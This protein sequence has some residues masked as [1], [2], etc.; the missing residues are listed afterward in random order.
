MLIKAKENSKF[1]FL[2]S[3]NFFKIFE[4]KD[5]LNLLLNSI[6]NNI[7]I[8]REILK[9]LAFHN[10]F[11]R[12]IQFFIDASESIGIKTINGIELNLQC[13]MEEIAKFLGISRQRLSNFINYLIENKII[14][15]N[16]YKKYLIKDLKKLKDLINN[17]FLF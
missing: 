8:E 16:G 12:I 6:N 1:Y 7:F 15:K 9:T 2:E 5:F 3:H 13:T 17:D 10:S 11:E 4:D 14:K